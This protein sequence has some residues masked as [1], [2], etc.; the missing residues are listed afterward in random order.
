MKIVRVAQWDDQ[1]GVA[2]VVLIEP[3][4]LSKSNQPIASSDADFQ[5]EDCSMLRN[6]KD[7]A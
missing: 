6:V 3:I 4:P 2:V 5:R 7:G 1:Q